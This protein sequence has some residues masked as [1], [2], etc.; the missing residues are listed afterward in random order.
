MRL[1]LKLLSLSLPKAALVFAGTLSTSFCTSELFAQQASPSLS[2]SNET[3]KNVDAGVDQLISTLE[4]TPASAFGLGIWKLQQRIVLSFLVN[5]PDVLKSE[6]YRIVAVSYSKIKNRIVVQISHKVAETEMG[7]L[8]ADCRD[9][10]R[11]AFE[12]IALDPAMF[13]SSQDE[14]LDARDRACRRVTS[15]FEDSLMTDARNP[16]ENALPGANLCDRIELIA[17]VVSTNGG[18]AAHCMK[19]FF[20]PDIS[21]R[22]EE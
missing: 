16:M 6:N 21:V 15:D 12:S 13:G 11:L 18:A 5:K 19:A 14:V 17:N 4:Q 1:L 20:D 2:L 3:Q 10:I 9:D 7:D 8:T 22:S